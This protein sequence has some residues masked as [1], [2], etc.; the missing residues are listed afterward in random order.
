MHLHILVWSQWDSQILVSVSS[1]Y[2]I[3]TYCRVGQQLRNVDLRD[4][5][6]LCNFGYL[7]NRRASPPAN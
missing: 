1:R 5:K 3:Y 4:C 2:H 6:V 7:P